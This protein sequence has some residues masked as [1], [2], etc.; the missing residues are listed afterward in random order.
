MSIKKLF[1]F[2]FVI[3]FFS[4]GVSLS[5]ELVGPKILGLQL[6]MPKDEEEKITKD[7]NEKCGDKENKTRY[8][9]GYK[10][11]KLTL[12]EIPFY[13]FECKPI[14]KI[15]D[16]FLKNFCDHYKI[17]SLKRIDQYNYEYENNEFKI[18][19]FT[20]NFSNGVTVSKIIKNKIN[21][22]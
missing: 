19:I 1:I 15:D 11:D 13:L 3:Y 22:K 21:F 5:G 18:R 8:P 16:N 4:V 17:P 7:I 20:G 2:L 9:R 12:F 10:D 6:G 14:L